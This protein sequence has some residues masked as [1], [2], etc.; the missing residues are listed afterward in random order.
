MPIFK[1]FLQL[2]AVGITGGTA[3]TAY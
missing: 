2:N 1:R 3:F